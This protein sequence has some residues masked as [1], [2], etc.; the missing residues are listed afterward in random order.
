M[1]LLQKALGAFFVIFGVTKIISIFGFGYGFAGTVGFVASLGYPVAALMVLAAIIVE[2]GL[3]LLLLLPALGEKGKTYQKY[4]AY[5]LLVF[6]IMATVMFHLPFVA[7]ATLTAEL[8]TVLKNVIVAAALY[9]VG[10]NIS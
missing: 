7:G 4:A 2:I 10:N 3:G 5:G 6:T 9:A 8:T 1:E